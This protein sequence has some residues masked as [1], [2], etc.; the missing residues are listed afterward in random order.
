MES[1][2]LFSFVF[3]NQSTVVCQDQK[4]FEWLKKEVLKKEAK[5][6]IV[7]GQDQTITT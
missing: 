5:G 2:V 1:F 7:A 4:Y 3:L 6:L